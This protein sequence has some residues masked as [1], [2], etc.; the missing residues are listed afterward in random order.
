MELL[1]T[2]LVDDSNLGK[3]VSSRQ[4]ILL[5]VICTPLY[6]LVAVMQGQALTGG[7]LRGK[8]GRRRFAIHYISSLHMYDYSYARSLSMQTWIGCA[9]HL[10]GSPRFLLPES[11]RQGS[12]AG[13]A[14]P[15]LLRVQVWHAH[16]MGHQACAA[17]C[18][19]V[20][21]SL[22][23]GKAQ[24]EKIT[25]D[26]VKVQ[27]AAYETGIKRRDQLNIAERQHHCTAHHPQGC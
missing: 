1:P 19:H 9:G 14:V 21:R 2:A 11:R 12:T 13:H 25:Y 22:E 10:K 15:A 16:L 7:F 6:T 23:R 24:G 8:G 3:P 26:Y 5:I 27:A 18:L 4:F 20:P 17:V